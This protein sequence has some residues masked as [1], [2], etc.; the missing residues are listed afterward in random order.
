MSEHP[1][2]EA[3]EASRVTKAAGVVSLAT[4][5][6][7][8]FGL[9]RDVAMAG[10][11]GA[12]LH[13]DA[14]LAAFRIPNLLRRLFGEGSL[15]I[16]FVPVF[17]GY[18]SN[19][20]RD[21]AFKLARS[22]FAMLS[23]VLLIV[24][25]AGVLLAPLIVRII[26]P[27]FAGSPIKFHL[28]VTLT[29]IMFPY[30]FFI[31]LVALSMGILNA[32]G[33]FSAPALAPVFLNISMIVSMFAVAPYMETPVTGLAIGVLAGGLLQLV[34]QLPVL[35]RRG[36]SFGQDVEL[37]HP[38]L[39]RIGKLMLPAVF[40][41][42]VQQ[43][44]ILV[45]VLLASLLSEGSVTYLYYADR[46]VQLPLG[47]FAIAAGTAVLPSLS[48]QAAAGDTA[49]MKDTF[50]HAMN[51]VL[52]VT[53]PS[54][55]GLIVLR[56]PIVALL[57][58]HGAFDATAT[59]LTAVAVLCFGVGLWAFSAV[60][61]PVAAF[62]ALEDTRTPV[63]MAAVS[64]MANIGLGVLLMRFLE[65]GGLALATSLASMLHFALLV[66]PLERRLGALN[67]RA[68]AYPACRTVVCSA[69]MGA[70]VWA[71]ACVV[72]PSGTRSFHSLLNGLLLNIG[73]GILVFFL[74]SFLT[75]SPELE[76]LKGLIMRGR[77]AIH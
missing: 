68:M 55:V 47:I 30:V 17:T 4:L 12:G 69:V 21:E 31:C 19:R 46:L 26:A 24:A 1:I 74:L 64:V 16:A 15:T 56:E 65:H 73:A 76:A 72:I 70:A 61:I 9:V 3:S 2:S 50:R 35:T 6:S 37:Y 63:K 59:G 27:G 44:N 10:F 22:A 36:V 7:R 45:G 11:F 62:Y 13:S 5:L 71:L 14:F 23:L 32:L 53:I 40:G 77:R 48:R 38:G 42:A 52:F 18:L 57:F 20:G 54:M 33:H 8:I 66:R 41:A 34:L 49:A 28:T 58:Q 29:R 39:K 60:R 51:M 67:W 75:K 43:I 25:L